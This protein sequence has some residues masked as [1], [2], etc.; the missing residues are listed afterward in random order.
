MTPL[1][2]FLSRY[3][4]SSEICN[5]LEIPRATIVSWKNNGKLPNPIEV[6]GINLTIW[7]REP[8]NLILRDLEIHMNKIRRIKN[9]QRKT[10]RTPQGI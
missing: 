9:H 6:P 7:E 2:L 1:E 5:L 4:T 3:I 8:L 10:T